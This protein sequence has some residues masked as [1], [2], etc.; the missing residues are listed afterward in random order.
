MH[1][2]FPPPS[3]IIAGQKNLYA[4]LNENT[5]NFDFAKNKINAVDIPNRNW[6]TWITVSK[7]R[8]NI[9]VEKL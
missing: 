1:R 7:L 5:P 8:E 9:L 2:P 6:S 4:S 3:E